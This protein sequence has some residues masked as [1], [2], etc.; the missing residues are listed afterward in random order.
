MTSTFGRTRS[1]RSSSFRRGSSKEEPIEKDTI[2]GYDEKPPGD[3][4]LRP[5]GVSIL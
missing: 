5:P 3:F 1:I 2:A 4:R